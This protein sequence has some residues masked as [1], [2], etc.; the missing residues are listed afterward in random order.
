MADGTRGGGRNFNFNAWASKNGL[1][2]TAK[3]LFVKH[4]AMTPDNMTLTSPQ[5]HALMAEIGQSQAHLIANVFSAINDIIA[6][7]TR[8]IVVSEEEQLVDDSIAQ[9]INILDQKHQEL[10][11]LK[12]AHP[13]TAIGTLMKRAHRATRKALK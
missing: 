4:G 10:E 11:K 7:E 5:I 2:D 13:R 8:K 12:Q 6:V 1:S 3:A 9:N